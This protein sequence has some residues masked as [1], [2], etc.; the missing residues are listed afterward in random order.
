L[1]NRFPTGGYP[2]FS[3]YWRPGADGFDISLVDV[4]VGDGT[5]ASYGNPNTKY[6][7]DWLVIKK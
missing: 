3:V 7:V 1:T 2:F 6:L 4:D 5:T